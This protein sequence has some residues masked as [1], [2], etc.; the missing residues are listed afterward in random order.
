MMKNLLLHT[1][2]GSCVQNTLD[3]GFLDRGFFCDMEHLV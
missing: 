3:I 1:G 2:T